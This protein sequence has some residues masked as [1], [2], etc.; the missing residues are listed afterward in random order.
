MK[1]Q[2]HDPRGPGPPAARQKKTKNS[3]ESRR[4]EREEEPKR[5]PNVE[6]DKKD[7]FT[8]RWW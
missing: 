1:T 4:K 6:G 2:V 8:T 7:D 3:A 5:G